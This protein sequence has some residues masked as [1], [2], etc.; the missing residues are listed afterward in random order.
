[1]KKYTIKRNNCTISV[2]TDS[3]ENAIKRFAE[4]WIKVSESDLIISEYR[5]NGR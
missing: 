2:C 4:I 3:L 5:S 1:M